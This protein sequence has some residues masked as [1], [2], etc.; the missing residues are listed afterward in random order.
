MGTK[1]YFVFSVLVVIGIT[2]LSCIRPINK[3]LPDAESLQQLSLL[4]AWQYETNE[5][6]RRIVGLVDDQLILYTYGGEFVALNIFSGAPIWTYQPPGPITNLVSRNEISQK[7]DLL[8]FT[9][10][11]DK[12]GHQALVVLD[13]NTGQELWRRDDRDG[14]H[15]AASFAI[16][17]KYIYWA[18]WPHYLAFDRYT[19]EL[20]W[21]SQLRTGPGGY[22]G[23]LYE[24]DEVIVVRP[25]PY[26]LD[27]NTGETKRSLDFKI[28]STGYRIYDGVIYFIFSEVKALDTKDNVVLWETHPESV[29]G[30]SVRWSPILRN[31]SLYL[32]LN[33]SLGVLDATT[34]KMI[35][36][37]SE[38]EKKD[39]VLYSNPVFV[40]DAVYVIFSDGSLR[41]LNDIDGVETGR[42]EFGNAWKDAALYAT[43]EMLF[44]SLGGTTLYAY[45]F[46]DE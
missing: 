42:V 19:G 13:A 14:G 31:D 15:A 36:G 45:T 38:F 9:S 12:R 20:I 22:H 26:V 24:D 2:M 8:A 5:R 39:A 28:N 41:T 34:G 43:D 32:G 35:W 1:K 10:F 23:L 6:I 4:T 16:G 3:I 37:K 33:G 27:A 21:Q 25:E 18:L 17:D 29:K 40:G 7:D 44:V 30:S 46:L 11:L